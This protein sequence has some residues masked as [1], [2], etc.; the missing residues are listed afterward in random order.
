MYANQKQ[1]IKSSIVIG[2][3]TFENKNGLLEIKLC[4]RILK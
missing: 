4:S 3:D 2:F 1:F